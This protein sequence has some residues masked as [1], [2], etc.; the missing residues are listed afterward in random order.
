MCRPPAIRRTNTLVELGNVEA[1]TL[2]K[3]TGNWRKLQGCVAPRGAAYLDDFS[4]D[5]YTPA[6]EVAQSNGMIAITAGGGYNFHF[7]PY[8]RATITPTDIAAI[9]TTCQARLVIANPNGPDD[10]ANAKFILNMGGD[11]WR[12]LTDSFGDGANNPGIGQ[13]RFK[14]VTEN[15]QAFN[16][17]T[18]TAA[19]LAATPPPLM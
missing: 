12:T 4:G 9:F 11:Y 5:A 1:Y 15:W 8:Q 2:S 18:A 13:G 6:Q 3:S 14:W 19:Q 10:R 16:F 7:A 17:C